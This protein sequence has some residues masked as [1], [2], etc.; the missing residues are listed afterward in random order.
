MLIIIFNLPLASRTQKLIKGKT[1]CS[2]SGEDIDVSVTCVKSTRT[3]GR[4]VYHLNHCLSNA[5]LEE[6]KVIRMV[7]SET[8][9]GVEAESMGATTTASITCIVFVVL[10]TVGGKLKE[11]TCSKVAS[12]DG[13]R[14]TSS[15]GATCT[16]RGCDG[17]LMIS[18]LKI[19]KGVFGWM[20]KEG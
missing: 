14:S 1:Q 5:G 15:V 12:G 19:A 18:L 2:D 17:C 11:V 9:V 20:Y 10:G 8:I 16:G 7:L 3:I 6:P 4:R 13:S